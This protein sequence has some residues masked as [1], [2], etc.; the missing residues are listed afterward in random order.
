MLEVIKPKKSDN[1]YA[2]LRKWR[3][4]PTP[5]NPN[6]KYRGASAFRWYL[7]NEVDL[8][9]FNPYAQAPVT[10]AKRDMQDLSLSD[11]NRFTRRLH[12]DP[13]SVLRFK[14][15]VIA[16]ELFELDTLIAFSNRDKNDKGVQSAMSKAL[17]NAG[18]RKKRVR[19]GTT[20]PYL[21]PIRNHAKWWNRLAP[22]WA[23]HYEKQKARKRS[24]Y[25]RTV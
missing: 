3:D 25:S 7:E 4:K 11:I 15:E 19:V 18:F 5:D 16:D 17:R 6:G 10:N 9:G 20:R 1:F 12:D 23:R 21:W 2:R 13:D 22:E 14:D 24:K 8:V